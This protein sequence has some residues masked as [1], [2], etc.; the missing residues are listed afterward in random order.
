MSLP[1]GLRKAA[2]YLQRVL[3]REPTGQAWW[4]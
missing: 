3:I 2:E 4:F 1:E